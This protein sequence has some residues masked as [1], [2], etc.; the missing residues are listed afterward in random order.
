LAKHLSKGRLP[1]LR[2]DQINEL[3]EA[4][5]N[6]SSTG[7]GD[8]APPAPS[9]GPLLS[10][11]FPIRAT[12]ERLVV[13]PD[14]GGDDG[15]AAGYMGDEGDDEDIERLYFGYEWR[16]VRYDSTTR[17]WSPG[18]RGYNKS[19]PIL[20]F[21]I[22][23][24]GDDEAKYPDYTDEGVLLW[25]SNTKTGKPILTFQ[26]PPAKPSTFVARITGYHGGVEECSPATRSGMYTFVGYK[27][28]SVSPD[29]QLNY[30]VDSDIGS[31]VAWNVADGNG[32][33]GGKVIFPEGNEDN[34]TAGHTAVPCPVGKFV[35]MHR[36]TNSVAA[37]DD[38]GEG[39]VFEGGYVYVFFVK[40]DLCIECCTYEDEGLLGE[41]RSYDIAKDFTR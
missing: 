25:P 20:A 15:S 40:N 23:I 13:P 35:T 9:K 34:C 1:G 17:K 5:Q 8:P 4:M 26:P 11:Q 12:L 3:T 36:L 10:G 38:P 22:G 24:E 37:S 7:G 32:T 18:Y 6:T 2:A 33:Y 30:G 16:E 27:V 19:N 29:G 21:P 28:T 31:G 39:N 14:P 41:G